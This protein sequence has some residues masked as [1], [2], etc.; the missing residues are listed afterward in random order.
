ME[1]QPAIKIDD[2]KLNQCEDV[3]LAKNLYSYNYTLTECF[4]LFHE[5]AEIDN[6][7]E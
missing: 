7:K 6:S 5:E 4:N 2:L 3:Q 1:F